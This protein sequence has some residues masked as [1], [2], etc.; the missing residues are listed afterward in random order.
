MVYYLKL[1]A[2]GTWQYLVY[3]LALGD[4]VLG[5]IWFTVWHLACSAKLVSKMLD[6]SCFKVSHSWLYSRAPIIGTFA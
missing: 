1:G 4:L 5:S 6:F 3:Y 2:F